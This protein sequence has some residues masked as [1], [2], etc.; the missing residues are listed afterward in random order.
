MLTLYWFCFILGGVFVALAVLGGVDGADLEPHLDADIELSDPSDRAVQGTFNTL[1]FI[2]AVVRS[3]KFWTFGL[4]FFGLTGLVL[5][6]L[7][8]SLPTFLIAFIAGVLGCLLGGFI[9]GTLKI[10]RD[11]QV[12]SLVRS[13]D[14]VGLSGTVELPIDPN[15]RGKVRLNVKGS[16]IDFVAYTDELKGFKPGDPVLV[17]GMDQGRLWVV[18]ET[19]EVSGTDPS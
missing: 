16:L 15:H 2:F 11:R 10:L 1:K 12:D 4:C 9:A 8:V 14:L 5:S 17:V 6:H 7:R 3:L 13:E 19:G 18:S